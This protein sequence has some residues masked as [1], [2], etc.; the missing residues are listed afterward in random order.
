MTMMTI[1]ALNDFLGSAFEEDPGQ[2]LELSEK[3][4]L[5]QLQ[6]GERHLRPGGTVSGPTMMALADAAMY[7]LIL[8]NIGPV[9]LAV[10]TS[11]NINFYR[12]PQP[13]PLHARAVMLK[14]GQRL[15][16]GDVLLFGDDPD[17]SVAQA[18]VTYS[19]PPRR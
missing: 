5:M 6:A 7:A 14:L 12:K 4:V 1:A 19:I 17:Q 11:L 13:G 9:A 18:S 3:H 16:V 2:V 10:T 15:A 8:G